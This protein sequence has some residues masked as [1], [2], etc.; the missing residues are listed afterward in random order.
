M[1]DITD[2]R[3]NVRISCVNSIDGKI[4]D[5]IDYCTDR[6]TT[7]GVN[8]N[9]NPD[10]LVCCDCT[11]DCKNK[12]KCQCWQL[13]ISVMYWPC[14]CVSKFYI[15]FVIFSLKAT[16]LGPSRK[17]DKNAG[18]QHRRLMQYVLTGIYECNSRCSCRVTCLNRVV[19][20][21][22][23]LRLQVYTGKIF[24]Y[25]FNIIKNWTVNYQQLF[26]TENRG[27]GIRCIDDIPKGQ[28]ICVFAGQLLTEQVA[29]ENGKRLGDEYLLDLNFIEAIELNKNGY[30][31]DVVSD[32]DKS[33]NILVTCISNTDTASTQNLI[34]LLNYRWSLYQRKAVF[35]FSY[36]FSYKKWTTLNI[37]SAKKW[38]PGSEN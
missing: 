3:E 17:I 7:E 38:W 28:F 18:Y 37:K 8:L 26:R 2:G 6:I 27:W 13:T 23:N 16:A 24:E 11:D 32:D 31:S 10:F 5:R 15:S 35:K 29:N 12:E 9:L 19:Q 33:S 14:K 21:P 25:I 1:L 34:I 4:P 36:K 22:L 30:E 20:R